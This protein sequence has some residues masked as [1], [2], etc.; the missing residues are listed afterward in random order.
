MATYANPLKAI[1]G[2]GR[3]GTTWA[4]TLVDSSPE[5]IYRF[6]PFHRMM[7][8]DQKFRQWFDKLK[9]QQVGERDIQSIYLLLCRAHPFI[10]KPPFFSE[11]LYRQ[12]TFGRRQMWPIAKVVPLARKIYREAYSTQPGPP[13]AFKEVTFVK[14][15]Q[16]LLERTSIPVVYLV[17]HPCAT[18]L[19]DVTGQMQ[20]KM[21]SS[22]QRQLRDVLLEHTPELAERF[23]SVIAGTDLVQR[24]A[25][26]WRCEIET[27]VQMVRHST[28]G[29]VL[30]Y[31]QLAEDAYTHAKELFAHFGLR[32]SE[33]SERYID[34]LYGLKG[35]G[36]HAPRRTGWG[37][38]YFSVYRNPREEKDA[39]KARISADD[40]RKVEAIVEDSP[41]VQFCAVLGHW[42]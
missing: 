6:E 20:G 11:K 29:M 17:R 39:W 7:A 21:P 26:L 10:N 35:D 22:R 24:T 28:N 2:P 32:F 16:N 34:F 41:V 3:S 30:T 1:V 14:P 27:C 5:V 36:Q 33:Q 8:V 12:S 15:L 37:H 38:S 13:L 40:R 42:S 9:R 19:S 31:E 18:V 25:L 4:G 23:E